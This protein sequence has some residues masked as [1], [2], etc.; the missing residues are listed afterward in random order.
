MSKEIVQ[1]M[2]YQ[3]TFS[4][5]WS[6]TETSTRSVE[7]LYTATPLALDTTRFELF[8]LFC[9]DKITIGLL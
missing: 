9:R 6:V 1:S 3:T 5:L 8:Q 4:G 2:L 7:R